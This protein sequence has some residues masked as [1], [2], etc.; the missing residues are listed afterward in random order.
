MNVFLE[1]YLG[2]LFYYFFFRSTQPLNIYMMAEFNQKQEKLSKSEETQMYLQ[3]ILKQDWAIGTLQMLL[4]SNS[5]GPWHYWLGW[6][7]DTEE[8]KPL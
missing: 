8:T 7:G 3:F 1:N 2:H 4:D 5:H 6:I